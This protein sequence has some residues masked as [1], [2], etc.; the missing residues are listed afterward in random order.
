M[1]SPI[2]RY[3]ILGILVSNSVTMQLIGTKKMAL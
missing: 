2:F 1:Y 3:S